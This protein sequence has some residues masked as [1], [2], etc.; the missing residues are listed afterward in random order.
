[1]AVH[2]VEDVMFVVV[3]VHLVAVVTDRWDLM[4]VVVDCFEVV[5]D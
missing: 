1:M 5:L 2:F 4:V 3:H